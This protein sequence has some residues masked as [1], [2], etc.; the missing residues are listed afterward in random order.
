MTRDHATYCPPFW[1]SSYTH[2]RRARC[3]LR[4]GQ[5]CRVLNQHGKSGGVTDWLT[6]PTKNQP[7]LPSISISRSVSL[8][9]IPAEGREAFIRRRGYFSLVRFGILRQREAA[10][11][12]DARNGWKGAY[13]NATMGNWGEMGS[14]TDRR[15]RMGQKVESIGS[16][17][18]R[19]GNLGMAKSWIVRHS[20]L[21]QKMKMRK[22]ALMSKFLTT[23]L[24]EVLESGWSHSNVE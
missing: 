10:V 14:Q 13:W 15:A 6:Q 5:R 12:V 24:C 23:R 8:V 20:E 1:P 18:E 2:H 11:S 16:R 3:S 19:G 17:T 4:S 7:T 22:W 9:H 21:N